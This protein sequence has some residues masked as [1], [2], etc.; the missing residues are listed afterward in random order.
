MQLTYLVEIQRIRDAQRVHSVNQHQRLE[1]VP[2]DVVDR[3]SDCLKRI[4]FVTIERKSVRESS[5]DADSLPYS[6][7]SPSLPTHN[8]YTQPSRTSFD[9]QRTLLPHQIRAFLLF[10]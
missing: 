5:N 6:S 9:A 7:H 1:L 3:K 2:F 10:S 8:T 4:L